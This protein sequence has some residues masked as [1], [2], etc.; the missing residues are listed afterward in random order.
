[1]STYYYHREEGMP[2]FDVEAALLRHVVRNIT[3][4]VAGGTRRYLGATARSGVR[5]LRR[6]LILGKSST[7]R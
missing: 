6:A 4:G 1:M 2:K 5:G 7:A 3:P